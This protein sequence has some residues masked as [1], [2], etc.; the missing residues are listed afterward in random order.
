MLLH[1]NSLLITK[2]SPNFIQ[3]RQSSGRKIGRIRWLRDRFG[4]SKETARDS[5]KK[6]AQNCFDR[7]K[8]PAAEEKVKKRL[9]KEIETIGPNTICRYWSIQSTNKI[10]QI[11]WLDAITSTLV[12]IYQKTIA[13]GFDTMWRWNIGCTSSVWQ[14]LRCIYKTIGESGFSWS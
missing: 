7:L 13:T 9:K 1:P 14:I 5:N 10:D 6:M 2:P 12:G 8:N 11:C 3:N 4:G